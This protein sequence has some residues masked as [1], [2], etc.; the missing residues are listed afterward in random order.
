MQETV[1]IHDSH[2]WTGADAHVE[3]GIILAALIACGFAM[4]FVGLLF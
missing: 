1:H 4:L 2:N 3:A